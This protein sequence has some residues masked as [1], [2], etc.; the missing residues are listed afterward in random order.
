MKAKPIVQKLIS[1]MLIVALAV[2]MSVSAFPAS[3]AAEVGTTY[4]ID[5]ANGNDSRDGK[6][7]STAWKTLAKV[8]DKTTFQPGDQILLKSGSVFTHTFTGN[9]SEGALIL[10]SSGSEGHPIVIGS[11]GQ[12]PKPIINANGAYAAIRVKNQQYFTIQGL[13]I[14]NYKI[15]NPDDFLTEYWRRSGIWIST[16]HQGAKKGITIKDMTIHDINGMSITGETTVTTVQGDTNV[17]KNANAGILLNAWKWTQGTPDA[18]YEDVL[19][20]DNHIYNV[21]GPGVS[22]DGHMQ[23]P[24]GYNKNVV[25][26]GNTINNTGADG[27]IVGVTQGPVVEYNVSYNAG[28]YGNGSRWIAG[29]WF[30]RTDTAL[31]Q[32]NEVGHVY[33]REK[34]HSDSAAFDTDILATRDHIFQ[35][36]YSHHNEGGF[37]MDMGRLVNG[38][39]ILRYNISVNDRRDGHSSNVINTTD[40]GIFYNNVFYNDQGTGFSMKENPRITFVNNIFY[41]TSNPSGAYVAQYPASAQFYYNAFYGQPAPAQAKASIIGDPMFVNPGGSGDGRHTVDGFK[42]Q[43]GSPLIGAGAAIS[44]NGGEDFWGNLLYLGRGDMG[45]FESPGST[46]GETTEAPAKPQVAVVE[47]LDTFVRLSSGSMENGVPLNADIFDAA[48]DEKIAS[49]FFS[50]EYTITGLTPDTAYTFYIKVINAAGNYSEKSDD[51]QVTTRK[52]VLLREPEGVKV[53]NWTVSTTDLTTYDGIISRI[54]AGS[55]Q[56]TLT[57]A[58]DI[59]ET[60]YYAIYAW[61]TRGGAGRARNAPY[62]VH[63]GGQ[64]KTYI[65]DQTPLSQGWKHLG[66]Q[67][68]QQGTGGYVQ[69]SDNA[70]GT[71]TADAVKLVYLDDYSFDDIESVMISADKLQLGVGDTARLTVMGVDRLGRQLDLVFDGAELEYVV[72]NPEIASLQNGIVT[73]ETDGITSIS[74][75][76][77]LD[78][79]QVTSNKLEIFVGRVFQIYEPEFTNAGGAAIDSLVQGTVNTSVTLINSTERKMRVTLIAALYSAEGLVKYGTNEKAVAEN[80]TVTFNVGLTM[81]EDLTGH[82]MRVYLWDSLSTLRPL[83]DVTLWP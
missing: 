55:G 83:T 31:M 26:R 14:T 70:D 50:N 74:V 16:E 41:Y 72:D 48:T 69:I 18:V 25:I 5:S 1:L 10:A 64:S 65:V 42:L 76:V 23:N 28:R 62:T 43:P 80:S 34:A 27:I 7:E 81:P 37:Y 32:Y 3:A 75:K 4:Y 60:G 57:W 54:P 20:E 63:S 53:G 61:T 39:N 73:G 59:P 13:E 82:Y 15:S 21:A 77:M 67:K 30:W 78:G 33:A 49:A 11:Y 71:V 47:V 45:A 68:L 36:N 12:G 51:I 17:N 40:T 29:M 24:S 56:G 19:L 38:K 52:S 58:T 79:V 2:S 22:I 6:S 46:A 9:K 35:Y 66:I 8:N 44:D